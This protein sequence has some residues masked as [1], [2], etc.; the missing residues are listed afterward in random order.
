[1]QEKIHDEGECRPEPTNFDEEDIED[2]ALLSEVGRSDR[3]RVG[4]RCCAVG[5]GTGM[6]FEEGEE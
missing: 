5:G 4:L 3:G 6:G 1:M 2:I